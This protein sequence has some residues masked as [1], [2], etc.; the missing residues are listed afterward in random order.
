MWIEYIFK[1]PPKWVQK[2]T[3]NYYNKCSIRPYDKIK[4]FKGRTYVYK[5]WFE[6]ITQ[7]EIKIH[8]YRKKLK[9]VKK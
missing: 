2:A 7:G 9:K 6:T 1:K 5:I 4:H 8:Y 3:D